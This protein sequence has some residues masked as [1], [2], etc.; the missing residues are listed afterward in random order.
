MG[1]HGAALGF[2]KGKNVD[3]NLTTGFIDRCSED[4]QGLL[5]VSV[6]C[7]PLLH[8]LALPSPP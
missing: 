1:Q 7:G 6:S 5:V 3:A 8:I 4:E 2:S